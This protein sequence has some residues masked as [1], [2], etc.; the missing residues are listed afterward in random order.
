[1]FRL[2]RQDRPPP[3][4]SQTELH[5]SS[6]TREAFA[7]VRFDLIVTRILPPRPRIDLARPAPA[8]CDGRRAC[9]LLQ[10]YSPGPCNRLK[11]SP[12]TQLHFVLIESFTMQST[13]DRI[14][15]SAREPRLEFESVQE[16]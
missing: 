4:H 2:V 8:Q 7:A 1:M 15:G 11:Q 13:F 9:I 14:C 10:C 12:Q 6:N 5:C 3:Q 16:F